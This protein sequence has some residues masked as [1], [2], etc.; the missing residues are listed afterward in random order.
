LLD[1]MNIY[2]IDKIIKSFKKNKIRT[3]FIIIIIFFIYLIVSPYISTYFSEKGKQ[4]ADSSKESL[5]NKPVSKEVQQ[6]MNVKNPRIIQH[7]EGE[8][9]PAIV[10]DR[11]VRINYDKKK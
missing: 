7:T 8:Q 3:I 2:D 6:P 5:V 11:D 10:S 1:K 4:H 9:S